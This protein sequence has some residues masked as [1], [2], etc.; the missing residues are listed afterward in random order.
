MARYKGI[1]GDHLHA[2]KLSGQQTEA[3]LGVA[4]LNRMIETGRPE[5]VRIA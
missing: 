3:A 2:R 5:S 1:L 4:V